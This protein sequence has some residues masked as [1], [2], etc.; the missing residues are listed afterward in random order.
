MEKVDKCIYIL[1]ST[2]I[3]MSTYH[4]QQLLLFAT[5]IITVH[6]D[7]YDLFHPDHVF[8]STNNNKKNNDVNEK[9][10]HKFISYR[11]AEL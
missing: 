7:R 3:S 8:K 1:W 4:R 11:L 2:S 10:A 6:N 9:R 5:I